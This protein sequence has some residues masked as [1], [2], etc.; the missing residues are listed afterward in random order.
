M[1]I[2]L[3]GGG[4]GLMG[5]R[6]SEL[7]LDRGHEVRHFSRRANPKSKI[8]TYQWDLLTGSYEAE[9]FAGVTHVINL[10]GAGIADARWTAARKKLIIESRTQS[11]ALLAQGIKAHGKSVVAYIAS[12]AVGYYGNRGEDIMTETDGPSGGFLSESVQVWEAAIAQV[13]QQ[14]QL[15]TLIIRTGVVLSTQGGALPKMSLPLNF[16]TSTYFGDGQ[17]WFSWIH[18]EDI[19]Q[20]FLRGVEDDQFRGLYNGVSPQACRN[21]AAA[22]ALIEAK[23][24]R[25]VLVPAPA[26]ALKLALGEMSHT[27]LDSTHVS[28]QKAIDAGF[29]FEYPEIVTALKDLFLT[30]A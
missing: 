8:P 23:E 26:F 14:T 27:I 21:K 7:L 29:R 15:P 5:T 4:T 24:K 9:A 16:F 30:K 10:A 17:Q 3:I 28:A 25:A 6:L 20:F 13:T 22:Q 2:V 18:I 1:A 11:T 12:S 19:C